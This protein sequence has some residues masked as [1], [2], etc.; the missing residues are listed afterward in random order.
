MDIAHLFRVKY[1]GENCSLVGVLCY[2]ELPSAELLVDLINGSLV[3]CLSATPIS[4]LQPQVVLEVWWKSTYI[5]INSRQLLLLKKIPLF[6]AGKSTLRQA[7]TER[8]PYI[9]YVALL[10]FCRLNLISISIALTRVLATYHHSH[11]KF[12]PS[13]FQ[14][15]QCNHIIAAAFS[16][17][18]PCSRS[19]HWYHAPAA[20]ANHPDITKGHWRYEWAWN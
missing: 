6:Q 8:L 10:K 17:H 1:S 9:T 7:K 5:N 16:L 20:S 4:F 13:I 2:G 19:R 12:E 18:R 3:V 15:S 11:P 14:S